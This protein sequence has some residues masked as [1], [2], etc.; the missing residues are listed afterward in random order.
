MELDL[1]T[2]LVAVYVIADEQDHTELASPL[3]LSICL[4][5]W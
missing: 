4:R 2:F 5:R 1:A 3:R